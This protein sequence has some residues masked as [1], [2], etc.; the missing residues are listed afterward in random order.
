M[1][2]WMPRWRRDQQSLST[3]QA[4]VVDGS[5][6]GGSAVDE[7]T[8]EL[9]LALHPAIG[10]VRTDSST[11]SSSSSNSISKSRNSFVY[12]TA[13]HWRPWAELSDD[14]LARIF[15][16]ITCSRT[17]FTTVP[18]VCRS[19]RRMSRAAPVCIDLGW[20]NR[21]YCDPVSNDVVAH[22]LARFPRASGLSLRHC[23]R[24]TSAG[25]LAVADCETPLLQRL[26]LY[27][28]VQICDAWL[29]PVWARRGSRLQ[30]LNLSGCEELTDAALVSLARARPVRLRSLNLFNC[31]RITDR[32]L[33]T[34]LVAC[35]GGTPSIVPYEKIGGGGVQGFTGGGESG[36]SRLR[37]LKLSW[38]KNL[39]HAVLPV[40]ALHCPLLVEL[41]LRRTNLSL[42]SP[43]ST[44]GHYQNAAELPPTDAAAATNASAIFTSGTNTSLGGSNI[45]SIGV[46]SNNSTITTTT[47]TTTSTTTTTT[48]TTTTT[49]DGSGV[50]NSSVYNYHRP[51]QVAVEDK[52]RHLKAVSASL[53]MVLLNCSL[54][55]LNL[56]DCCW[57]SNALLVSALIPDATPQ[58]LYGVLRSYLLAESDPT[59]LH[60]ALDLAAFVLP[61]YADLREICLSGCSHVGD[62]TLLALALTCPNLEYVNLRWCEKVSAIGVCAFVE[63]RAPATATTDTAAHGHSISDPSKRNGSSQKQDQQC[64]EGV[65]RK[66]K[67]LIVDGCPAIHSL[68]KGRAHMTILKRK[69]PHL[70]LIIDASAAEKE[71]DRQQQFTVARSR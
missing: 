62:E 63:L 60:V 19:W 71:E 2:L 31:H 40:V 61:S 20:A 48:A 21:P 45:G 28:C 18:A 67:T 32:G 15:S 22:T 27:G 4:E 35:G 65:N 33:I 5:A 47:T 23:R 25:L 13:T 39:T 64:D 59:A 46:V 29:D 54:V 1:P 34:L 10:G 17:L 12:S 37:R 49:T 50:G 53:H 30:V 14:N 55:Q 44:G 38:C 9:S 8:A 7:V 58:Q 42:L 56:Q 41:K 69:Y 66:L 11:S 16:L 68:A 26:S 24:I 6:L 43:P 3:S 52:K 70:D 51:H 57:A 36:S